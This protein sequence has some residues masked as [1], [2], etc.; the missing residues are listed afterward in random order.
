MSGD[1]QT[2]PHM[3]MARLMQIFVCHVDGYKLTKSL[4]AASVFMKMMVILLTSKSWRVVT[5]NIDILH[6]PRSKVQSNQH[7]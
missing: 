1:I 4:G 5:S 7:P 3:N 2:V 6:L